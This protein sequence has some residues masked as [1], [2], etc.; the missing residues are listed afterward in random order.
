MDNNNNT[1]IIIILYSTTVVCILCMDYHIYWIGARGGMGDGGREGERESCFYG[2]D[3][4]KKKNIDA[5]YSEPRYLGRAL[6][7]EEYISYYTYLCTYICC[8]LVYYYYYCKGGL[9][10]EVTYVIFFFFLCVW[11]R[12][13][14]NKYIPK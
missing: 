9:C 12:E 7:F 10:R 4:E 8:S 14:Q 11:K 5:E 6:C 13:P 1:V 3:R 2:A